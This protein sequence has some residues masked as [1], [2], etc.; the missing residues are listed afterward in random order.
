MITTNNS[1]ETLA[2]R[3][4]ILQARSLLCRL[5][6]QHEIQTLPGKVGWAQAGIGAL[7]SFP[8][9]S[10]LLGMALQVIPH[11]RL[12]RILGMASRI[13]L[14]AKVACVATAMLQRDSSPAPA[15]RPRTVRAVI[16][17]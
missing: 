13:L 5:R 8:V 14:V 3:K 6:I 1:L 10:A 15:I 16:D 11:S 17:L 4:Q 12:A 9:R 7:Q 2:L